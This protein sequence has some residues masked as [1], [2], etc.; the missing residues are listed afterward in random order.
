MLPACA[1]RIFGISTQ[2]SMMLIMAACGAAEIDIQSAIHSTA[3][4]EIRIVPLLSR[5][6]V[7]N[8]ERVLVSAIVEAR[9]GIASVIANMG[10]I[11]TLTLHPDFSRGGLS[12]DRSRGI[13]SAEWT[14]HDLEE[15]MY[16]VTLTARDARGHELMDNSLQ[17]SDPI[18]GLQTPGSA[19]Y[20]NGGL[21]HLIS[22]I[23]FIGVETT[24]NTA[25]INAAGAIVFGCNA[26]GGT[27]DLVKY[28]EN[29]ANVAATHASQTI[30]QAFS[31]AT[32]SVYDP[33]TDTALFG[34]NNTS[35]GMIAKVTLGGPTGQ[36]NIIGYLTLA[37]V[38]NVPTC[39]VWDPATSTALFG[40]GFHTVV[41]VGLGAVGSPPVRI[42]SL[43]MP[44]NDTNSAVLVGNG[45][46]L[47]VQSS[48]PATVTKVS[49]NAAN[50]AP[51]LIGSLT[52]I[53]GEDAGAASKGVYEP[54]QNEALIAL[55]TNPT[56]VVKVNAGAMGAVP[57]RVGA[58]AFNAGNGENGLGPV[59]YDTANKVAI[60]QSGQSSFI[61][62]GIGAAG[63]APTTLGGLSTAG[64]A[65]FYG[66][67][68]IDTANS[69][70]V[71]AGSGP[72][73]LV[74]KI[75]VN[76]PTGNP[77]LI[78]AVTPGTAN[79][80]NPQ[81]AVFDP[82][83]GYALVGGMTN[84]GNNGIVIKMQ[85]NGNAGP[86]TRIGTVTLPGNAQNNQLTTAVYDATQQEALFA[87]GG[88]FIFKIAMNAG[89]AAPTLVN[90]VATTIN[91]EDSFT[92]SAYSPSQK[93]AL[94]GTHRPPGR[95][96]KISMNGAGVA[97][98]YLGSVPFLAGEDNALSMILD[99]TNHVAL[100]GTDTSPGIIVKVALGAVGAPPTRLS[101]LTLNAGENSL[102]SVVFDAA[103]GVALFAATGAQNATIVKVGVNGSTVSAPTRVA[104]TALNSGENVLVSALFDPVN[105]VALFAQGSNGA[106]ATVFKFDPGIV[107]AAPTRLGS[108]TMQAGEIQ[109]Y[110]GAIDPAKALAYFVSNG[111]GTDLDPVVTLEYSRKLLTYGTKFTMPELGTV[112][113]V[114]FFSNFADGSV[115]LG[116]MSSPGTILWQS[117]LLPNVANGEVVAPISSG[118]PT[119]LVL[120]AGTYYFAFITDSSKP[121]PS[122]TAGLS[123]DGFISTGSSGLSL[124][125]NSPFTFT[126]DKYTEYLT[127][128]ANAPITI[129]AP[130]SAT[131]NPVTAGTAT[132][133]SVTANGFFPPLSYAWNFGDNSPSATGASVPHIYTSPG[134]FTAQVTITDNSNN[135]LTS[136]VVATVNAVLA[137]SSASAT[138][139]T[140]G[141]GQLIAF[142]VAPTGGITPV[143]ASWNF[144][145]GSAPQIGNSV[146]HSYNAPG[147][148]TAQVTVADTNQVVAQAN[149]QVTV[150]APLVGTGP[151]SDGD[152]FSDSFETAVNT[153]PNVAASTPTGMP[154]TA[155]GIK[156]LI[157]SKALIKLNFAKTVGGDSISFSGMVAVPAGFNP[158][159]AKT[160]FIAGGVIKTLSLT[161]K[162]KGVNGSDSIKVLLKSK[163]GAVLANPAAKYS[164]S[165]KKGTFAATL[166]A[167][168]LTNSAAKATPVMVPFTF[169]FN[170]IV[171]QKTQTMRYTAKMGKTGMAK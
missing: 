99:D 160:F 145:D 15:K 6:S 101:S 23:P 159:G 163:A 132:Q 90:M 14:G 113:D 143:T 161:A 54:S 91:V 105:R 151:D 83:T 149:V 55:S 136:S 33:I 46:A 112:T 170:N 79:E 84:F 171:Y 81:S 167:T 128:V 2:F 158:N 82:S 168:G 53:A 134:M 164:V 100:V 36:V 106:P 69:T 153:D 59:V 104:V 37:N 169:I 29:A 156:T 80:Q 32:C 18:A 58:V 155:G 135:T 140:A 7:K 35:P 43:D 89:N 152:G 96:T 47:F 141:T 118:T 28:S 50:A 24:P 30:L 13:Y 116:I 75:A 38:D 57:T 93:E 107:S 9:C 63:F 70:A 103:N 31:Q 94:F 110:S 144:G 42:G 108:L 122:F 119:S 85:M 130:A 12:P 65:A 123:G 146:I 51:T 86:P 109:F 115:R 102:Q 98:T 125:T 97:A 67:G 77:L 62:V 44:G 8:G 124:S 73:F 26:G 45:E 111:G 147:P 150:V 71:F 72:P 3:K 40:L 17:F 138:P 133:L 5:P 129:S 27:L 41:K 139:S 49:I 21:Q 76:G 39:A 68:V 16:T 120:P 66:A 88:P 1:I 165:F 11:E 25:V 157:I 117:G 4:I 114:R 34:L 20:P 142:T 10:G 22:G 74:A 19:V 87:D 64:M 61:K 56:T 95:V 52:L 92:C 60:V 121:V 162:G 137:I 148:Y 78:G 166:S 127:Y 154:A 48:T 131:P 126:A